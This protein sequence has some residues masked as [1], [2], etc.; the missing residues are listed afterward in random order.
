MEE[1]LD[2]ELEG[3]AASECA[4]ASSS[5]VEKGGEVALA[6]PIKAVVKIAVTDSIC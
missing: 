5:N 2:E 3:V 4:V 1:E 6:L